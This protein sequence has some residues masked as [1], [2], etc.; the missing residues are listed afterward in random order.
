VDLAIV[1]VTVIDPERRRVLPATRSMCGASGSWRWSPARGAAARFRAARTVDGSGRF[2]IPGLMD[3]HVHLFL[4]EPTA[5]SLNLLLANGVTSIREMSSD[6]WAAAGMT[7]GCVEDY[8]AVQARVRAGELAGP[9]LVALTSTMVMGPS[10]LKLPAGAPGFITPTDAAGARALVDYLARRG[11][12]LIKTHDSVPQAAF[13]PLMAAAGPGP[14]RRRACALRGGLAGAARLG[15]RSIEHARDLLYDCSAY[16]P[17][18]RRREAA[19]ADGAPGAA[20]PPGLERL[21]RTVAE[22]DAP[23]CEALLRELAATG[24][25]YTPTHVTREMEARA[26][27]AAYRADPARRYVLPA[28]AR[29]WEADLDETAARPEAERGALDAF[30]RHGLK[31]TGLAHRAGVPVM[32]GTDANDTMIVPGFSLHRELGLLAEAGLSPMEVLRDRHHH[33]RRLPRPHRRPRRDQRGQGGGSRA[34]AG[35]SAGGG[36]EHGER[37]DG[38]GQRAGVHAGGAGSAAGGGGGVGGAGSV[39][40]GVDHM[41][42]G[43]S[44]LSLA[45]TARP[46]SRRGASGLARTGS[47]PSRARLSAQL[48]R[49]AGAGAGGMVQYFDTVDDEPQ[50]LGK[51]LVLGAVTTALSGAA[52]LWATRGSG[53]L[54]DQ[55][56]R[57]YTQVIVGFTDNRLRNLLMSVACG[58]AGYGVFRLHWRR[59]GRYEPPR[60]VR[61][62]PSTALLGA[63]VA[64]AFAFGALAPR[65]AILVG[66]DGVA[67][68]ASGPRPAIEHPWS[69]ATSV[70]VWCYGYVPR[71]SR[72]VSSYHIT[73]DVVFSDGYTLEL[74]D[75]AGSVDSDGTSGDVSADPEKLNS[76]LRIMPRSRRASDGRTRRRC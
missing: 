67:R 52:W 57:T 61:W 50:G 23:R 28:R 35:R 31:I 26:D 60:P 47:Q 22:F 25:V 37:G 32:A 15:Y 42:L 29:N 75:L 51:A 70:E 54:L 36:R 44:R 19:V 5:P 7:S 46:R 30:F 18:F 12:G 20:R 64:L 71:R 43:G 49:A 59:I 58:G 63:A 56:L 66:P 9:E 76:W 16:G 69:K 74:G 14:G 6:C 13:A 65:W 11:I 1:G 40:R 33:P 55:G 45:E 72:Q 8:R 62:G 17:E 34:A 48:G 4:P 38:G 73:Y 3:M 53:E 27:E 24:V 39:R 41:R 10:R 68:V 21:R 2:L